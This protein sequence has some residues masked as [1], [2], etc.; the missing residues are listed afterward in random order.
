[1][2]TLQTEVLIIG[3]GIIGI[4]TA[5]YLKKLSP[6]TSVTLL[7]QFQA[8]TFTS[9]QSG[10][11]YRNWWPH[12]LMKALTERSIELMEEIAVES[13]ERINLTRRGYLLATRK[14][15]ISK[16]VNE[17]EQSYVD[18]PSGMIRSHSIGFDH[19]Y[20]PP[21]TER[22]QDAPK[23]V[24]ILTSASLG[25]K[26]FP[27]LD[28]TLKNIIH[29][30]QAG[31]L[32]SQQMA[33]FMLEKFK[34]AGGKRVIGKVLNI[35]QNELFHVRL[36]GERKKIVAA[37]IVNAAG[38]FVADIAKML[39]IDLPVENVLQQKI[40]FP[41]V[42]NAIPRS[43][44][45]TIDLDK[46]F[47]NWNT[48]EKELLVND[49]DFSWLT[50][51]I[52]GSIHCRPEGGEQSNWVKLGWAFNE[53]AVNASTEP[54]LNDYYPEIVVRGAARLNPKLNGYING[55]PRKMIHYGGYYTS[56]KEN[57]PLIG[58]TNIEGFY[59]NG[60][61]SG[62]GTMAACASGELC[63]QWLL[64]KE[65]ASYAKSFSLERYKD[66]IF[67]NEL[68]TYDRGML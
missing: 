59:I 28:P 43:Q 4:S 29:I 50:K 60:A 25:K 36:N 18:T 9:A 62:F 5:Y 54:K 46:Q 19:N 13:N 35:E 49:P 16:L 55:L 41:D 56:T 63:S 1:M 42:L 11:N 22:W 45:F 23:G 12:P 47:I 15:D 52:S 67:M 38:P 44:P 3:T 34:A 20:Q 2:N 68:A 10:E 66:K 7:D 31:M 21:L 64:N 30:R 37:Q 27:N 58:P 6:N 26:Y 48:E 53:S 65:L 14:H 61:M 39:G 33:S 8:M 40:A 57:F 17:I 32:D 24:D 51:E